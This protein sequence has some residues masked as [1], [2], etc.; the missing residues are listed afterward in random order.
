MRER[1]KSSKEQN[2]RKKEIP[3]TPKLFM[4]NLLAIT[5]GNGMGSKSLYSQSTIQNNLYNLWA[6]IHVGK[7]SI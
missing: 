3:P 6:S 7:R 5:K 4:V 1:K 2:D